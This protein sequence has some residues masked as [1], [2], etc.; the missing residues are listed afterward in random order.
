MLIKR[1]GFV[2]IT[3][4]LLAWGV[5]TAAVQI[6]SAREWAISE[7]GEKIQGEFAELTANDVV[8]R[9]RDGAIKT[10]PLAK[11]SRIDQNFARD[12]AIV[13]ANKPKQA[14]AT[15]PAAPTTRPDNTGF[16]PI[17]SAIEKMVVAL[18]YSKSDSTELIHLARK[19]NC[20]AWKQRLD[21]ARSTAPKNGTSAL[22]S[23]EERVVRELCDTIRFNIEQAHPSS[24]YYYLPTVAKEKKAQCVGYSQ[25]VYILGNSV[26]LKIIPIDVKAPVSSL[27]MGHIACLAH[28][29]NGKVMIVDARRNYLSKPFVFNEKFAAAG[30]SWNSKGAVDSVNAPL[31]IRLGD[32]GFL[33]AAVLCNTAGDFSDAGDQERAKILHSSAIIVSPK[34]SGAYLGR[35]IDLDRMG[36]REEALAD[37]DRAVELDPEDPFGHFSRGRARSQLGRSH[38]AMASYDQAI[39]LA[40]REAEI[41]HYRA[42]ELEKLKRPTEAFNDYSKAIELDPKFWYAYVER[43]A[44][45]GRM[46]KPNEAIRDYTKAIQLNPNCSEALVRRGAIHGETGKHAEAIADSNKALSIDPNSAW[47]LWNRGVSSAFLKKKDEARSDLQKAAELDPELKPR[48]KRVFKRHGLGL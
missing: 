44:M 10:V 5:L 45:Y 3:H 12:S 8:L 43:G 25:L 11:L 42:I 21:Q 30:N 2:T 24:H 14:E 16:E 47:A 37:F 27:R 36:Q 28:L 39:K 32:E 19:W 4:C 22:A 35:G 26:G 20:A 33:A 6:A 48:L 29:S 41:Y 18:K 15:T 17:A 34:Y 38:E 23:V 13:A 9:L 40:P 7:T 31:R 46:E 1:F